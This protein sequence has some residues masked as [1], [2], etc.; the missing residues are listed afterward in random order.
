MMNKK[1]Q[2][3]R[4]SGAVLLIAVLLSSVTLAIGLGVYN[5]TYKELIL[6]SFWKQTQVAFGAADAGLECALYWD[7]RVPQPSSATCFGAPVSIWNPSLNSSVTFTIPS[8]LCVSIEITKNATYPFT[9]IKVR[10]YN[11]C[12]TTDPR[13][14]ERGLRIDY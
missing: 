6:A 4:K 9:T 10:G 14:V 7:T 12:V 13:R 1:I 8:P 3:K 11:T 2:K 5:R